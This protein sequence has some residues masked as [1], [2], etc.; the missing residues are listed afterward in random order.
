MSPAGGRRLSAPPLLTWTP[1]RGATYYNVQL[2]RGQERVLVRW[3][4]ATSLSSS[5]AGASTAARHVLRRGRYCWYV[6]PGF[7]ERSDARYGK[8]LGPAL[9]PRVA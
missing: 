1:V 6:W 2:L 9:L 8:L 7:G 3:P 4:R 5:A